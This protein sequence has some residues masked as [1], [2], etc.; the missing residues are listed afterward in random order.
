MADC[1]ETSEQKKTGKMRFSTH[2]WLDALLAKASGCFALV[3]QPVS[4]FGPTH[5]HE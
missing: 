5:D 2:A 3:R 4:L 1:Q